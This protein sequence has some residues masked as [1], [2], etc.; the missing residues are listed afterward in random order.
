MSQYPLSHDPA[1]NASLRPKYGKM[2]QMKMASVK[3][4]KISTG[5]VWNMVQTEENLGRYF[6]Q[7]ETDNPPKTEA[8]ALERAGATFF[9]HCI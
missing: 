8:E 2:L 5:A 7:F 1:D 4:N 6:A 9:P 3:E